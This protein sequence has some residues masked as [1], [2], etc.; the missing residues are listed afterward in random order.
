M[1]EVGVEAQSEYKCTHALTMEGGGGELRSPLIPFILAVTMKENR[2]EGLLLISSYFNAYECTPPLVSNCKT[3]NLRQ[4]LC[5]L[6][7]LLASGI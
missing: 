4:T 7:L 6:L 1:P 5:A 3:A 2:K